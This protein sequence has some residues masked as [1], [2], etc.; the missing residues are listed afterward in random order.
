MDIKSDELKVQ[1]DDLFSS[2]L[3]LDNGKRLVPSMNI[4]K[5]VSRQEK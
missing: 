5:I 4:E 2:I 3:H 1:D